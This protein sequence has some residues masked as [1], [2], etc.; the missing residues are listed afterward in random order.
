MIKNHNQRVQIS[1]SVQQIQPTAKENENSG[2]G[3]EVKS[4]QDEQ[5][6]QSKRETLRP[7][8]P[9]FFSIIFIGILVMPFM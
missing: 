7:F 2:L 3:Q 9:F 6:V 4:V 8:K 5:E 1:E